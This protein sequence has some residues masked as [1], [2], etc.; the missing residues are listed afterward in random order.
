MLNQCPIKVWQTR[1]DLGCGYGYEGRGD[2]LRCERFYI[3]NSV[4]EGENKE[5]VLK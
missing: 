5:I 4:R 1:E 3:K 2:L